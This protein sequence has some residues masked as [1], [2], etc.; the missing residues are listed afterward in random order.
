MNIVPYENPEPAYEINTTPLEEFLQRIQKIILRGGQEFLIHK[1]EI[2]K[3]SSVHLTQT[4][5]N[6]QNFLISGLIQL[7]EELIS[8]E[9]ITG[10]NQENLTKGLERF[11]QILAEYQFNLRNGLDIL[12]SQIQ[13]NR[14]IGENFNQK[15]EA[16][17]LRIGEIETAQKH[18]FYQT[19]EKIESLKTQ[20]KFSEQTYPFQGLKD[21][22][23]SAERKMQENAEKTK[24]DIL[25]S[26]E[27]SIRLMEDACSAIVSVIEPFKTSTDNMRREAQSNQQMQVT[28]I[29]KNL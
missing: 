13:T 7:R 2:E 21:A 20:I 15:L 11:Y 5:G 22:I 29:K 28:M 1:T 18:N 23:N 3:Q 10:Q 4:M 14:E 25:I 24:E 26:F 8:C 9:N 27:K 17:Y 19:S 6:S 16:I 12:S